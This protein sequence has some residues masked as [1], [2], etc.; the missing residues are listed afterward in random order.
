MKTLSLKLPDT[1]DDQLEELASSAPARAS[2][3]ALAGDL[4]GSIEGPEDLS[5]NPDHLAGY[6][7]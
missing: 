7:R 3:T 1:L 6:G 4:A 5:L 2:F